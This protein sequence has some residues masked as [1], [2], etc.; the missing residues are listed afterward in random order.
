MELRHSFG[1]GINADLSSNE[2]ELFSKSYEA[3]EAKDIIGG[4]EYF[5]KSLMNYTK[6]ESNK[7]IVITK[8]GD[9]LEFEIFQGS[10]R[11]A[12]VVTAQRVY[13]EVIVT[14]KSISFVELNRYLLERNYQ[15]TYSCYFSDDMFVKLKISLDNTIINPHK[16]FYPL[17]EIALNSDFDK[18]YTKSEFEYVVL[19][20]IGHL[21]PLPQ[22]ELRIK[23]SFF[24]KWLN[25]T[26]VKIQALPPNDAVMHSY[27][28]LYLFFKIDYLISPKYNLYQKINKK[29]IEYYSDETS[30]VE[31]KNDEL[32]AFVDELGVISF[33]DFSKNFY[34]AK[35]TFNPSEKTPHEEIQNFIDDSLSK[36]RWYK[37][38]RYSQII[39]TIYSYIALHM[40][41][42]F[43]LH[44]VTKSLLHTLIEVLHVDFFTSLGYSPLYNKD[45]NSFAK[46][47]IT[48]RVDEIIQ[49]HQSRFKLLKPF[50]NELNYTSLNEFSNSFYL[51]IKN[52][53]FEEI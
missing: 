24:K 17:R 46:K 14:R 22:E 32:L 7:N 41:Y 50:G 38:N 53:N 2:E 48:S 5:L 52:L 20:D 30:L 15:L 18:E 19:E 34:S 16:I 35:Y 27:V 51:H 9:K 23:Y 49:N 13:A 1:R 6:E 29:I 26:V 39:P 44:V 12:G 31:S 47:A 42:N 33:D 43:G 40:T 25:E 8:N 10:V 45:E 11:I 28:L 4:Y 37:N 3:F 36:I 21:M